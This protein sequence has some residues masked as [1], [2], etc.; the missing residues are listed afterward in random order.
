MHVVVVVVCS[1]QCATHDFVPSRVHW[2]LK[3]SKL[4]KSKYDVEKNAFSHTLPYTLQ[5]TFKW[6]GGSVV[7]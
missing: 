3:A 6:G 5:L 4:L 1:A 2:Y 7:G